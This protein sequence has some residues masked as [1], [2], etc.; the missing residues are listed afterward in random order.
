MSY[1]K[2]N[3]EEGD[4]S[5][6]KIFIVIALVAALPIAGLVYW[7]T[8]SS[9]QSGPPHL[10]NA[11]RPGSPEFEGMRERVVVEFDPDTNATEAT[12]PLGDVVMTITPT[13]R[14]FTGRTLNGLELRATVVDSQ[15]Q[16]V[17]EK[18]VIP[19]PNRQPE[20]ENNKVLQVPIT[21][22]GFRKTDTRAN[23]KIELTGVRFK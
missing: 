11:L 15:G 19:I 5:R 22:E 10:E 16:P 6:R 8:R 3:M 18:T 20:L 1:T 13:I 4:A 9:P 23:I 2:Q 12:R 21:M 17:Q 7:V 14:N